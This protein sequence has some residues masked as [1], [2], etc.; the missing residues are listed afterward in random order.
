MMVGNAAILCD[1][2]QT[3]TSQSAGELEELNPLL[4][5]SP[6]RTQIHSAV[7]LA[8]VSNTVLT[9]ALRPKW[10]T[11]WSF[12][13]ATGEGLNVLTQPSN[14]VWHWWSEGACN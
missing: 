8:L 14:P 10:A 6:S 13:V 11:A 9:F 3:L 4:G 5:P 1:W 7:L 2:K 12:G